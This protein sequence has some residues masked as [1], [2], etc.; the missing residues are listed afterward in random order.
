M[1]LL[2]KNLVVCDRFAPGYVGVMGER[3]RRVV[4]ERGIR[5]LTANGVLGDPT[6]ASADKGRVYLD[7]L[8]AFVLQ[9]IKKQS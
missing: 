7:R 8:T 2:E 9:E 4:F 5:A 6:T 1:M 3:E